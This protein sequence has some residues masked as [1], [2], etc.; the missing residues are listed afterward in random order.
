VVLIKQW[1]SYGGMARGR[2]DAQE[3]R[4]TFALHSAFAEPETLP[5][6]L[7]RESIECRLVLVYDE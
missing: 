1:D 2:S 3:Q 7:D 4:A 6:A 5:T